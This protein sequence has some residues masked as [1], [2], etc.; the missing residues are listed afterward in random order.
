[1]SLLI[2]DFESVIEGVAQTNL[3]LLLDA[4]E[5]AD[6]AVTIFS[7]VVEDPELPAERIEITATVTDNESDVANPRTID[8]ADVVI[9]QY[10]HLAISARVVM[11]RSPLSSP[12]L[13]DAV[14]ACRQVIGSIAEAGAADFLVHHF[15]II[16]GP[17][18]TSLERG[19]AF[20]GERDQ[21]IV[22]TEWNAEVFF[23]IN[24]VI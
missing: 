14:S 10:K 3:R 11:P 2:P 18:Q 13:H 8:G 24:Q 19:L 6:L 22:S 23:D 21:S 4:N 12:I 1:M 7:D 15:S 20:D 5:M 16:D 17:R 9:R